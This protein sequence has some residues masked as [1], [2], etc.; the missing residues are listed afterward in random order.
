MVTLAEALA[1][2]PPGRSCFI[3]KLAIYRNSTGYWYVSPPPELFMFCSFEKCNGERFF[4][5]ET[6]PFQVT[7]AWK[8]MF[9][10]YR[11]R[12]CKKTLKVYAV[13]VRH[14]AEGGGELFKYGELPA[15]G[16]HVPNRVR[17]LIGKDWDL[18]AKGRRCEGQGLGIAA[19]AYY[20]RV[21]ENRKNEIF[22]AICKVAT[23][24]NAPAE[25][26]SS[27]EDAKKDHQFTNAVER[28]KPGLPQMLLLDGENPLTLLHWALSKGLHSEPDDVCLDLAGSIRLVLTEMCERMESAVKEDAEWKKAVSTLLKY[29]T[30]KEPA[31]NPDASGKDS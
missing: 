9:I 23:K 16:P 20:R 25:F 4:D 27:L 17:K 24:L 14:L 1:T 2:K 15:F 29:K 5:S 8:N 28:I 13:A 6:G 7:E 12:H 22:D 26:L 31:K 19:F 3:S 10:E 30:P 11:C 21:V 18:F